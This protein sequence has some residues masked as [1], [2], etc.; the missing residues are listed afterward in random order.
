MTSPIPASERVS[1]QTPDAHPGE[2]TNLRRESADTSGTNSDNESAAFQQPDRPE[3]RG[4]WLPARDWLRG[5]MRQMASA[6][7]DGQVL[8][9]RQKQTNVCRSL[10]Q[11]QSKVVRMCQGQPGFNAHANS[12]LRRAETRPRSDGWL[13]SPPDRRSR[14]RNL[15]CRLVGRETEQRI[16]WHTRR[17]MKQMVASYYGNTGLLIGRIGSRSYWIFDRWTTGAVATR[18]CNRCKRKLYIGKDPMH[19]LKTLPFRMQRM[20]CL[21]Y[22]CAK[23]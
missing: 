3:I 13:C 16:E 10:T 23:S 15:R 22:E 9:V 19:E 20:R 2:E 21:C 18:T 1:D 12:L 7:L 8:A 11:S 5:V 6:P 4:R 17:L 14:E